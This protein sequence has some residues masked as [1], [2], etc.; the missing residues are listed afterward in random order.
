VRDGVLT[1]VETITTLDA[2]YWRAFGRP[3][4]GERLQAGA[5][6]PDVT[7]RGFLRG[8]TDER[9]SFGRYFAPL[10]PNRPATIDQ[11]FADNDVVLYDRH[12]DPTETVNLA[13]R[14]EHRDLVDDYR[15]RL[16]TLIDTEIGPELDA[17]VTTRP[18][19]NGGTG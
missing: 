8:Y 16:E 13:Y 14:P 3:D 7:K 15:R 1:A 12:T 19:L 18:Q 11:L 17:W 4:V 5:L 9:Y 2:D 6:R 10:A